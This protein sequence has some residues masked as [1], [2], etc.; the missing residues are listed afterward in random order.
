LAIAG[1]AVAANFSFS[2]LVGFAVDEPATPDG[3]IGGC[4][5]ADAAM[6]NLTK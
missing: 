2:R 1:K 5:K 6:N 4:E 3:L